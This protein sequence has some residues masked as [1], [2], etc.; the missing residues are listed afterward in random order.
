MSVPD[1]QH[2]VQAVRDSTAWDFTSKAG[3]CAYSN[4]VVNALYAE[5]SGFGHLTKSE[6]QNHC[7]DTLGRRHA[8]DVAL[9]LNTGQVVDFIQSAG[10]GVPPPEN[11][12]SWNV[13]PENEYPP[14]SWFAP[15]GSST[16]PD[17]PPDPPDD[18]ELE[19]RV[20]ALEAQVQVLV[21]VNQSQS[22]IIEE[23]TH[24]IG[25]LNTQLAQLDA[26]T[27]KQPL[28]AYKGRNWAGTVISNPL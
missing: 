27:V 9:Y 1:L 28:P 11:A 12:V 5:D 19:P 10:Y 16:P 7:T 17:P 14:S 25:L 21:A 2:I 26:A 3:L 20:E 8:V 22:D 13:G 24:Q 4:A 15:D 18:S 23:I 6:A